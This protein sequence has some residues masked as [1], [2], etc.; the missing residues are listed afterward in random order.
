MKKYK[1]T[2][3]ELLVVIAIIAILASMLLPALNK[4]RAT[5]QRTS[6]IN[7]LKQ[8][9][10]AAHSYA[11]DNKGMFM[12]YQPGYDAA[13]TVIIPGNSEL[14]DGGDDV[15]W[16]RLLSGLGYAPVKLGVCPTSIPEAQSLSKH[17]GKPNLFASATNVHAFTYGLIYYHRNGSLPDS[18]YMLHSTKIYDQDTREY[19]SP[20]GAIL[21]GDSGF[22]SANQFAPSYYIVHKNSL[23]GNATDG[24][25]RFILRHLN[26]G[27]GI[28]FDGH[29]ES[30]TSG[31]LHEV[32]VKHGYDQNYILMAY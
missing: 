19:R 24:K 22:Y 17:Y 6:C 20:S 18:P 30:M 31:R 16:F 21:L 32:G 3:V 29:A 23:T 1:F 10:L 15:R 28:F 9:G 12:G 14:S 27:N 4:A 2:L 25:R 13:H 11:N 26:T 8:L 5:A 7:Q